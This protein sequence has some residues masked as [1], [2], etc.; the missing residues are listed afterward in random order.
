MVD[1][2]AIEKLRQ[3]CEENPNGNIAVPAE[4]FVAIV[5]TSGTDNE[6]FLKAAKALKGVV[7]EEPV[8]VP[9]P[10]F[11]ELLD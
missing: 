11:R 10:Q 3:A 8:A 6:G 7:L 5:E 2:A 4:L 1:Q 9:S